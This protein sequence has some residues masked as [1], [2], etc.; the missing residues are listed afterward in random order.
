MAVAL[1]TYATGETLSGGDYAA[2]YG[3]NTSAD[4]IAWAIS[5]SSSSSAK[6]G[7]ERERAI[8][9]TR[10]R[11]GSPAQ[12]ELRSVAKVSQGGSTA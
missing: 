3:F 7:E 9:V 8:E 11:M 2:A 5:R 10:T 1:A 6:T 4:G 12:R